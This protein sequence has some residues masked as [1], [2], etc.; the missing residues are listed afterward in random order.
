[1]T[2]E[3]SLSSPQSFSITAL[4]LCSPLLKSS[5][6]QHC[7]FRIEKIDALNFTIGW[8]GKKGK[9]K[10]QCRIA[11]HLATFLKFHD[12][13]KTLY[14]PSTDNSFQKK[15]SHNWLWSYSKFMDPEIL[16]QQTSTNTSEAQLDIQF[17]KAQSP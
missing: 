17:S 16:T 3:S 1:M 9:F 12:S 5:C 2:V 11:T 10:V 15:L 4:N 14:M 8:K 13:C 7:N 6:N